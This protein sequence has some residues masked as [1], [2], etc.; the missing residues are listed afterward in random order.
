M[1]LGRWEEGMEHVLGI[2]KQ[3]FTA[4]HTYIKTKQK[5]PGK[6]NKSTMS[7]NFAL[8]DVSVTSDVIIANDPA[9]TAL[10]EKLCVAVTTLSVYL[11]ETP[12]DTHNTERRRLLKESQD[13]LVGVLKLPISGKGRLC[14]VRYFS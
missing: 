3:S 4:L 9:Q 10:E 13:L 14:Q 11:E 6:L 8:S 12:A 1:T 5:E 7:L 2:V